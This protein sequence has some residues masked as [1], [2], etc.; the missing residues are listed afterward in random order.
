MK[1]VLIGTEAETKLEELLLAVW[2]RTPEVLCEHSNCLAGYYYSKSTEE[3]VAFDNTKGLNYVEY[4][5]TSTEAANFA[6][7]KR[8]IEVIKNGN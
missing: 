2:E 5:K 8:I 4:F 7:G 6:N 3:W 1:I